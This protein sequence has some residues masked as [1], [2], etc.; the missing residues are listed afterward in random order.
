[1]NDIYAIRGEDK[2]DPRVE[3]GICAARDEDGLFEA[4]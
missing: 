1:M 4:A 2:D 3:V